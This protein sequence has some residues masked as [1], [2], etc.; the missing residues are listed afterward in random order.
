MDLIIKE[1]KNIKEILLCKVNHKVIGQIPLECLNTQNVSISEIDSLTFT[2][3]KKYTNIQ[4]KATM[5]NPIYDEVVNER[6]ICID[7][8]YY[9]IKDVEENHFEESK[10]VTIYGQEKKLEKNNFI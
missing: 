9:V 5:I 1:L 2:I 8:D 3:N 10:T 4:N 7:G 6:F